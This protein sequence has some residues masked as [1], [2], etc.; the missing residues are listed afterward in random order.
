MEVYFAQ[1]TPVAMVTK[2]WGIFKTKLA[3]T[4]FM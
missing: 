3:K 2:S 1:T 4:R